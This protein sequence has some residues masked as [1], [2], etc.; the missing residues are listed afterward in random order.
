MLEKLLVRRRVRGKGGDASKVSRAA[1]PPSISGEAVDGDV[2]KSAAAKPAAAAKPSPACGLHAVGGKKVAK[3]ATPAV[4][5][6]SAVGLHPVDLSSLLTKE[7]ARECK[8]AN[9]LG[10]RCYAEAGRQC[11]AASADARVFDETRRA[12]YQTGNAYWKTV[13]P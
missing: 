3:G 12:A 4:S 7:S 6:A 5:K 8:N 1:D 2:A 13:C 11:V 9:T 10:T